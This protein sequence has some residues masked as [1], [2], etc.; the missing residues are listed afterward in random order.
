MTEEAG[1]RE[2]EA[3]E[4]TEKASENSKEFQDW[5][6]HLTDEE[7]R[8]KAQRARDEERQRKQQELRVLR[9]GEI[10]RTGANDS[11]KRDSP[12]F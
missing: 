12:L 8:R 4:L 9:E 10:S 7:T 2:R 11:T 5:K 6:K 3:K 1:K